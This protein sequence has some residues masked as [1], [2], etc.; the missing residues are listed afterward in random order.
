MKIKTDFV[1][2]SSSVSYCMWGVVLDLDEL[3]WMLKERPNIPGVEEDDEDI[4]ELM[5]SIQS[6]LPKGMECINWDGDECYIGLN[7]GE[8]K[9]NE[10]LGELK[11]RVVLELDKLGIKTTK[12][13]VALHYGEKYD[14]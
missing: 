14:G 2:N 10:T 11:E 1:T 3:K 12:K 7:P 5:E 6:K 4:Y 8:M 13:Q 9:D